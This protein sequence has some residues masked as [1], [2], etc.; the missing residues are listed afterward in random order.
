MALDRSLHLFAHRFYVLV[1]FLSVLVICHMRQTKLASSLV[2]FWAYDNILIEWLSHI[3]YADV[4]D[5]DFGLLQFSG[6]GEL[7]RT[8]LAS[9]SSDIRAICQ[10]V[11][12]Y[13]VKVYSPTLLIWDLW[14]CFWRVLQRW[15]RSV[16]S[17]TADT[18]F[19]FESRPATDR[20]TSLLVEYS[21]FCCSTCSAM[22]RWSWWAV[23]QASTLLA[24][25]IASHGTSEFGV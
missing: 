24:L 21:E 13:V 19:R 22:P 23:K 1:L 10:V 4:S 18:I 7:L 5:L 11:W 20:L 2:S 15:H 8:V 16:I 9:V 3:S 17:T 12:V 14:E 6:L 25:S